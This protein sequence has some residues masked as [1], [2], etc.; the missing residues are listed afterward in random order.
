MGGGAGI[1][2]LIDTIDGIMHSV[3]IS[4]GGSVAR[5][6]SGG[7]CPRKSGAIAPWT[8]GARTEVGGKSDQSIG[9]NTEIVFSDTKEIE[10]IWN[11][12]RGCS[13]VIVGGNGH[14]YFVWVT[15]INGRVVM[16]IEGGVRRVIRNL[17][18]GVLAIEV[19]HR[20]VGSAGEDDTVT[21]VAVDDGVPAVVTVLGLGGVVVL[22][23]A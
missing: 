10:W 6:L 20:D 4:T 1:S 11:V 7:R 23:L 12:C 14:F 9:S 16:K 15:G 19:L 18:D 22:L 5:G 3:E 17:I 2:V 13:K 8:G 21:G